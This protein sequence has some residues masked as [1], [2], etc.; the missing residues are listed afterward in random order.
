MEKTLNNTAEA[1]IQMSLKIQKSA[2]KIPIMWNFL[3]ANRKL[4][5]GY[6]KF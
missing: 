4:P 3:S 6:E 2:F 1:F 5:V